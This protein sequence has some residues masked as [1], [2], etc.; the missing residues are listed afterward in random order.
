MMGTMSLPISGSRNNFRQQP[1]E[2]HG[3]R[4][5]AAVRAFVKFLEVSIPTTGAIGLDRTLRSGR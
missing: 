1:H 4:N 3:G 2:N 5:F